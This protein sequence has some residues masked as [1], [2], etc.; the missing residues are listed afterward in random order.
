VRGRRVVDDSFLLLANGGHDAVT[1]TLPSRDLGRRWRVV[2]DT[3]H[4]DKPQPRGVQR[5]GAQLAL[6]ERSLLLLR[7]EDSTG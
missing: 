5:P 4:P 3:A 7:C 2:V 1:F 6:P